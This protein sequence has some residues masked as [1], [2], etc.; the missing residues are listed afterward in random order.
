MLSTDHAAAY[1]AGSH[2]L[3]L[4]GTAAP[5]LFFEQLPK[6]SSA[7]KDSVRNSYQNSRA[8]A[9][10][11]ERVKN[12]DPKTMEGAMLF[13]KLSYMRDSFGP[14]HR[15]FETLVSAIPDYEGAEADELAY[16]ISLFRPTDAKPLV[17]ML[18]HEKPRARQ[19]AAVALGKMGREDALD[20]LKELRFDPDSTVR[21]AALKAEK[22]IEAATLAAAAARRRLAVASVKGSVQTTQAREKAKNRL[23]MP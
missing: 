21:K 1:A 17:D 13:I 11:A 10:A 6:V 7:V 15:A 8:F 9:M 19:T 20:E 2:L 18:E 12:R 4:S 23:G 22:N 14:E 3:S 5:D 16:T